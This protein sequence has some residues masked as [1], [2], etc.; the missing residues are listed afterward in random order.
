MEKKHVAVPRF[1]L[2]SYTWPID[3]VLH[4]LLAEAK[5]REFSVRE[6]HDA[7]SSCLAQFGSID[8]QRSLGR[9]CK[10]GEIVRVATG[11]YRGTSVL[12]NIFE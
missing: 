3:V 1:P 7:C 9:L 6:A 8:V 5:D 4:W 11:R 2:A 12:W 10:R